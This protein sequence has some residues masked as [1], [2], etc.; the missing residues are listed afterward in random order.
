[1]GRVIS[2]DDGVKR[3]AF[4]GKS[5]RDV[6]KLVA[7]AGVAI[8]DECIALC[9]DII[10]E[11]P[12]FEEREEAPLP[13]PD[14]IRR[15]LDRYVIGQDAAKRTL[16]VAVTNHF[17]RI[18]I[19]EEQSDAVRYGPLRDRLAQGRDT[20]ARQDAAGARLGDVHV[21][22]SNVL[23]L[24]PTGVG[25]TYLAQTLAQAMEVPFAIADA[26]SLTEAGYAGDDV[27]T[28][29]QRLV[30]A[31]DGDVRRASHG[32]VYI[33]EIDKISRRGAG[34]NAAVA[35]DVSGEGVQQSLLKILEGTVANVPVE[36]A[37]RGREPET[38]RLDTRGILFICG[39]AFVGLD[40]IVARR[41][42]QRES[43]FATAWHDRQVPPEDLLAQTTPDDLARFGLLPEFIGRLPIVTAL[44][45]LVREDLMRILTEPADALVRQY[46]RLFAVDDVRLSFTEGAI[47]AI[48]DKAI[49]QG[50]GARGL[51]A[52]LE[53]TLEGAMYDLGEWNDVAEVVVTEDTVAGG[54]PLLMHEPQGARARGLNI[55]RGGVARSAMRE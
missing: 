3:C 46:Q 51:R 14:Q 2:Y 35:R 43:G 42:G 36:P 31:A 37:R 6:H 26:T 52:I 22:K 12:P 15:Y 54:V 41:L 34:E 44:D 25:K 28:L 27:E 11:D 40:D 9:V 50:T 55:V 5:E 30:E 10:A 13:S 1:M 47:G 45:G 8:C 4:C 32:I 23:L 21:A 18:R 33:D 24:G 48:A 53:K 7:G 17:K 29:L 19:E 16:A 38:V 39:G 49:A 20:A